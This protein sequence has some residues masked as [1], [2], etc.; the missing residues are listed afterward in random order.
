MKRAPKDQPYFY[1]HFTANVERKRPKVYPD[2]VDTGYSTGAFTVRESVVWMNML[3][4]FVNGGSAGR[5]IR[6]DIWNVPG[7]PQTRLKEFFGSSLMH[8]SRFKPLETGW[9]SYSVIVLHV[10]FNVVNTFYSDKE[11]VPAWVLKGSPNH[12][13]TFAFFP[14][15]KI[16]RVFDTAGWIK[17]RQDVFKVLENN[18]K[19]IAPACDA[20]LASHFISDQKEWRVRV[21]KVNMQ[22]TDMQFGGSCGIY[23]AWIS[24]WI[25]LNPTKAMYQNPPWI[26]LHDTFQFARFVRDSIELGGILIPDTEFWDE[27]NGGKRLRRKKS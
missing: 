2:F 1:E 18:K 24:L 5:K 10:V 19:I 11:K 6:S 16:L 7:L 4:D 14:G 25:A 17:N 26:P 9:N 12:A 15:F 23:S 13:V 22:D 8:D 27:M 21:E 3:Q 20:I